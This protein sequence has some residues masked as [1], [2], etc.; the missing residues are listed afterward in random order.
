MFLRASPQNEH[1]TKQDKLP[2]DIPELQQF[3]RDC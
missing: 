1:V 2:K 3:V